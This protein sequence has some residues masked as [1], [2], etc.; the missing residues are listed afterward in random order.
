MNARRII[1]R[2]ANRKSRSTGLGVATMFLGSL[3]CSCGGSSAGVGT[4]EL[5]LRGQGSLGGQYQLTNATFTISGSV[6][7]SVS[8]D[9]DTVTESLPAGL[10]NIK[11][12]SGWT[13]AK[14]V[15]STTTNVTA[16]LASANPQPAIING[17]QT[18]S[19]SWV[20]N[21]SGASADEDDLEVVTVSNGA[22]SLTVGAGETGWTKFATGTQHSCGIT[23]AGTLKCWGNNTYGALGYGD[24]SERDAPPAANVN[25][26]VGRT[27]ARVVTGRSSLFSCA[28]L[29]DKTV[30]CWGYNGNGQLGYGDTTTRYNPPDPVV[31]LGSSNTAKTIAAGASHV[32]VILD[33]NLV[34]CWGYNG[35]G[36][37]GYGDTTYRNAPPAAAINLGPGSA[38]KSVVA[39]VGHTCVLLSNNSVK[40]WGT[41]SNGELGY[42]DTTARYA[43]ADA[44]INLGAG[45]SAKRIVA[46][47]NHTCAI[48][49]N[50]TVKCWGYNNYGQLGYGDTSVRTAPP[51]AIVNLGSGR[52]AKYV[53]AGSGHTCALLDDD[54]VKCWGYNSYGQLGYEDVNQRSAPPALAVSLGA[55]HVARRLLGGENHTCALL[56]DNAIKCWGYNAY[57]T[58][59]L[60]TGGT[61]TRGDQLNEMGDNLPEVLP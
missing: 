15:G 49:D 29:D 60:G 20:F 45:R 16:T 8:G 42:G 17:A 61:E 38:A 40:C 43:P 34:K 5:S 48:L 27:V 41:N 13:L 2:N 12:E 32:C 9:P 18:T 30:K 23:K 56:N 4:L 50:D 19:V 35:T 14:V 46:G 58:F 39:G 31:N 3:M 33:N 7:K 24:T 57:G 26:G 36:Q 53:A 44:P 1:S 51:D 59:G 21:V 52:T 55:G 10:Y 28:L 25:V 11:L 54:T 22:L 6:N 47:Y 37:L